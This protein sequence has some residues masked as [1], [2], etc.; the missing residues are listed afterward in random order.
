MVILA[1]TLSRYL[2]DTGASGSRRRFGEFE[3]ELLKDLACKV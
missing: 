1:P 2:I 3:V